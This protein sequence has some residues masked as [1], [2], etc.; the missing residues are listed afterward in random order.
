MGM[1]DSGKHASLLIRAVKSFMV[2]ALDPSKIVLE[3]EG[4]GTLLTGKAQ[5]YWSPN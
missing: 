3:G 4:Q 2:Q 5:N 1:T